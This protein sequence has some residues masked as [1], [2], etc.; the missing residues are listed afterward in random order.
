V[1]NGC[2]LLWNHKGGTF[3]GGER[4]KSRK[5][6]LLSQQMKKTEYLFLWLAG[7]YDCEGQEQ[8]EWKKETIEQILTE[9]E[10][11]YC[12]RCSKREICHKKKKRALESKGNLGKEDVVSYL[13][14]HQADEMLQVTNQLYQI[15]LQQFRLEQQKRFHQKFFV[16]Q[17]KAAAEMIRNCMNQYQMEE[18]SGNR[19]HELFKRARKYGIEIEQFFLKSES[20]PVELYVL[21]KVR[22]GEKTAREIAEIFSHLLNKRL[23]PRVHCKMSAGSHFVWMEFREE[24]RFY[25]LSG[26]TRLVCDGQEDCGEQFT[27]G[28]VREDCFVAAICDGLGTGSLPGRESR[29][30]IELLEKLLENDIEDEIAIEMV[31]SSMFFSSFHER[32]VTLDCLLIDLYTGIGKFI[33]L[34]SA[35]TFVIRKEIVEVIE[36]ESPPVGVPYEEEGRFLRKKFEHG[37]MIVMVSDGVLDELG[38]RRNFS[39]FLSNQ[40]ETCPQTLC[41]LIAEQITRRRDDCTILVLGI[42][43]K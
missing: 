21:L 24:A 35:E 34:G 2:V 13:T 16:N 17:Y 1:Y 30:V 10:E 29:K 19:D 9:I 36:G 41:D 22:K 27:L 33:K 28:T 31:R 5:E 25:V 40:Q 6:Y 37:D 42:W 43:N 14:C 3:L 4:E 12:K 11:Q 18:T 8:T 39:K 32:Y 15:A 38:G 26:G 20:E 23:K 7:C